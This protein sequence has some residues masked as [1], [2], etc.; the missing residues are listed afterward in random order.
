[1]KKYIKFKKLEKKIKLAKINDSK[2]L[3]N[4]L[5][6]KKKEYYVIN[7]AYGSNIMA[8]QNIKLENEKEITYKITK[9]NINIYFDK[10][11]KIS[12]KIK[13][14]ILIGESNLINQY[15]NLLQNLNKN[16]IKKLEDK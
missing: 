12:F 7:H 11:E 4:N 16:E 5:C 3:I 8:L 13:E 1:M 10:S 2:E 6:A 9:E 14:E 15:E